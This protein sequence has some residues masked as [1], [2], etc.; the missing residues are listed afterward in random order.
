MKKL[1]LA[2]ILALVLTVTSSTAVLADD[3]NGPANMPEETAFHLW[4][5]WYD[6]IIENSSNGREASGDKNPHYYHPM[7]EGLIT[8]DYALESL[9]WG[10]LPSDDGGKVPSVPWRK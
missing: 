9:A 4:D 10:E 2:M 6:T 8:A 5:V 3:G 7:M 1:A